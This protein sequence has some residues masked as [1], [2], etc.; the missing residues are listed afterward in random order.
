MTTTLGPAHVPTE[1]PQQ[2]NGHR[3]PPLGGGSSPQRR[4]GLMFLAVILSGLALIAGVFGVGLGYRAIDEAGSGGGSGSAGG[5]PS[6]ATIHL[7]EFALR[8][9]SVTLAEGGTLA[10][11][12]DG[13][14][15]HDLAESAE[16]GT[17]GMVTALVVS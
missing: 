12:N 17:F 9:S 4:D 8:P 16:K 6:T 5:A 13:A 3:P 10:V 2:A 15:P 11:H 1:S 14:V 7:T